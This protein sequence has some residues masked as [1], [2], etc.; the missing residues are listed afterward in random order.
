MLAGENYSKATHRPFI[1]DLSWLRLFLFS[2]NAA[3]MLFAMLLLEVLYKLRIL[4]ERKNIMKIHNCR[5]ITYLL[6]VV[7][8]ILSPEDWLGFVMR[9]LLKVCCCLLLLKQDGDL[10]IILNWLMLI[11]KASYSCQWKTKWGKYFLTY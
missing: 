7:L 6:A 2:V 1:R 10:E 4:V 5:Q 9:G 8:F 11:N 3:A